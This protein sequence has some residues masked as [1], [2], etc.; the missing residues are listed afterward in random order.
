MADA[1]ETAGLAPG[2]KLYIF[3]SIQGPLE[4]FRLPE[5]ESVAQLYN[6]PFSW[7]AKPDYTRPYMLIGLPDDEAARKLGSR[8]VS[9]KHVWEFWAT[10]ETYEELH[11]RVKSAEC[12]EK[13]DKYAVDRDCRWKFT[14]AGHNRTIPL[15]QQVALVN[16]FQYMAFIGEI[17]LRNPM[18]EVGLFEE[19]ASD[20]LRGAKVREK[21][22]EKGMDP[23]KTGKEKAFEE[24]DPE[25]TGGLRSVWM[26][27]KICDTSRHMMDVFDLKKRAYIGTT[28]MEAE[29]S[30]LMANQALAAPGK[31]VY[32]PFVGTGSML[33]TAAAYGAMTFGS[34]IDGRQIRGK[35][36]SIRHSA[37]QYGVQGRIVDCY[38]FDMTQHPWRTGEVFD[39]IVTDPPYGVRAGAKRLGREEGAREVLPMIVPGREHEGYHHTFPDYVPPS[40]GWPMEEVIST[41]VTFSLYLLRPG[42]RLVFFLPTDNAVYSD[43][44]IPSIPGMRLVSNTS[45]SFG[46]WARRLITMEK[47]DANEGEWRKALEGL[48]RGIRREGKKSVWEEEQEREKQAREDDERKKPG[49]ADFNR[50]YFA[51]FEEVKEGIKN[52][53]VGQKEDAGTKETQ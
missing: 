21:R 5:I 8:L 10:A 6:I 7:P 16:T 35:K 45:Q 37:E 42:G 46:K 12:R 33:L 24:G 44:D 34:D 31:W 50:R 11:E 36:T 32:D 38:T 17:D 40:V 4:E 28:S 29:V 2:H 25:D 26:G 22:K 49:H 30:L 48:D 9:V 14:I 18:L 41:L 27:R 20:P 52:L 1:R 3:F 51:G 43:V 53:L 23:S 39:A 15:P 19:Y 47:T 13:W